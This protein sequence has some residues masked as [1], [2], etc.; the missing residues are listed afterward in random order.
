[1]YFIWSQTRMYHRFRGKKYSG[2][3]CCYSSWRLYRL[4]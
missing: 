4:V 2:R 3:S 1:M